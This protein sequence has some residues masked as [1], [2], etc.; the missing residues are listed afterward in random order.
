MS[1]KAEIGWRRVDEQGER[2]Q[3]YA[4]HV[5]SEWRF[6]ERHRRYDPWRPLPDPPLEDWLQLLD[7][8]ERRMPRRRT[9]PAEVVR[10]RRRIRELFPNASVKS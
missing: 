4:H 10:I 3:V 1:A 5:G 6:F 2:C 9:P 8:L 7:A